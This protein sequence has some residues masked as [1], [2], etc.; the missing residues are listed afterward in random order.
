MR[1]ALERME[2]RT[3]SL[4]EF[5]ELDTEFH[6]AVAEASRNRLVGEFMQALRDSVRLY[7]IQAVERLGDWPDGADVL[8][9]DHRRI[10]AA[11]ARGDGPAAATAVDGHIGHAYPGVARIG[12]ASAEPG[13][14]TAPG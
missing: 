4:P 7:A 14:D 9:S 1:T 11:I 3:L 12:G 6:V 2:D 8:R 5:N 13:A 10:Y